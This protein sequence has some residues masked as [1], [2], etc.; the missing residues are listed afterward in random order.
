MQSTSFV[1]APA[2]PA[3]AA[4]APLV[5]SHGLLLAAFAQV[6]DP[7]RRQGTRY[8][9]AAILALAVV[10]LLA[11]HLSVSAIA[12]WGAEEEHRLQLIGEGG[13]NHDLLRG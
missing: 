11:N 2:T 6:T 5:V 13:G 10:A 3:A 12:P 8:A 9:L 7:R 4:P 1:P